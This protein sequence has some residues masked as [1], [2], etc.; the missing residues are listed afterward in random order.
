MKCNQ[1]ALQVYAEAESVC[2]QRAQLH[3][4]SAHLLAPQ[5]HMHWSLKAVAIAPNPMQS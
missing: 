5:G 4:P 3:V 2:G 1:H